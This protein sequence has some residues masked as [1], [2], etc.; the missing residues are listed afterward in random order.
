MD[1]MSKK[2]TGNDDYGQWTYHEYENADGQ[3]GYIISGGLLPDDDAVNRKAHELGFPNP[4]TKWK[5]VPLRDR[6]MGWVA[7]RYL[8][9]TGGISR[10][11]MGRERQSVG[12]F[13]NLK[14]HG[15]DPSMKP[16]CLG[17]ALGS[18]SI[19][20]PIFIHN[21]VVLAVSC[22][23]FVLSLT[24]IGLAGLLYESDDESRCVID[25]AGSSIMNNTAVPFRALLS[26]A[27]RRALRRLHIPVGES[28][29][30]WRRIVRGGTVVYVHEHSGTPTAIGEDEAADIIAGKTN[31]YAYDRSRTVNY[32]YD[33]PRSV[34][35]IKIVEPSAAAV[36]DALRGIVGFS[37]VPPAVETLTPE[38][39]RSVM[40]RLRTRIPE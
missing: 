6:K 10:F 40:A 11:L 14:L 12:A 27:V 28:P 34:H 21:P 15:I 16:I 8:Y 7:T 1:R 33:S 32:A 30:G 2:K 24:F 19:Y 36:E 13:Y 9:Y 5:R 39:S 18:A 37:S 22:I 26:I 23:T 25:D 4:D 35:E 3:H 20:L 17:G 38:Q 29:K 31:D